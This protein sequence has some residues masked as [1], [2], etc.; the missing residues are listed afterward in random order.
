MDSTGY[1]RL[2][3]ESLYSYL[4]LPFWLGTAILSVAPFVILLFLGYYL[5]GVWIDLSPSGVL[6]FTPIAV[7]LTAYMLYGTRYIRRKM[8]TLTRYCDTLRDDRSKT[9]LAGLYSFRATLVTFLVSVAI[10]QPVYMYSA[11][12]P[13]YSLLQRIAVSLPFIYWNLIIATMI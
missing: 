11:L 7:I 12:P 3:F 8:E 9:T 4:R 2:W 5:A 6:F 10:V 1:L 13:S